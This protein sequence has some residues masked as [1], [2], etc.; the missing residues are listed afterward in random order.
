M[1]IIIII[2]I[3]TH[4]FSELD[5]RS[6]FSHEAQLPVA[7][8]YIIVIYIEQTSAVRLPL[9]CYVVMLTRMDETCAQ[10]SLGTRLIIF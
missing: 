2:I 5:P 4:A 7:S 10:Q 1:T 8:F 9:C 6:P 3:I